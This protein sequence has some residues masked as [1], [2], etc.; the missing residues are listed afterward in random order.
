MTKEY[1]EYRPMHEILAEFDELRHKI[2]QLETMYVESEGEVTPEIAALEE[3]IKELSAINENDF[4]NKA[5][6]YYYVI[7][8]YEGKAAIEKKQRE[9]FEKRETALTKAAGRLKSII[10]SAMEKYG[11]D[12][13]KSTAK[14]PSKK[15]SAG[16]VSLTAISYPVLDPTTVPPTE[17]L[18]EELGKDYVDSRLTWS[19]TPDE[20]ERVVAAISLYNEKVGIKTNTEAVIPQFI[21]TLNTNRVKD[22]LKNG[23]EVGEV[24]LLKNFKTRFK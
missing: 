14:I 18:I 13:P 19:L 8:D 7:E 21:P 5:E 17:K 24:K 12:D 15:L 6:A 3:E 16:S 10:D 1:K 22:A 4:I 20:A 23:I 11:K 9:R 2:F